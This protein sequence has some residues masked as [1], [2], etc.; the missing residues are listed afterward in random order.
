MLSRIFNV[1]QKEGRPP[2]VYLDDT[3]TAD[4]DPGTVIL[5]WFYAAMRASDTLPSS[6]DDESGPVSLPVMTLEDCSPD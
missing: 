5:P 1:Q 3:G 4:G 6:F 2:P